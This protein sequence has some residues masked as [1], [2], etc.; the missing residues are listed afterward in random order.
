MPP[1]WAPM[2]RAGARPPLIFLLVV[3]VTVLMIFAIFAGYSALRS[4]KLS[5]PTKPGDARD[6]ISSPDFSDPSLGSRF[7]RFRVSAP[8]R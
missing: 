2:G 6:A 3:P 5:V 4:L 1:A 7:L 8:V